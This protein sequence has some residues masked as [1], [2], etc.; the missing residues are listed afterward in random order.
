MF[1][2]LYILSILFLLCNNIQG[3]EIEIIGREWT[4]GNSVK[5]NYKYSDVV[6]LGSFKFNFGEKSEYGDYQEDIEITFSAIKAYKGD[7]S[8]GQEINVLVPKSAIGINGTGLSL[9]QLFVKNNKER[10]KLS[11]EI[12]HLSNQY[13]SGQLNKNKYEIKKEELSQA[14]DNISTPRIIPSWNNPLKDVA[15]FKDK[16]CLAYLKYDADKKKYTFSNAIPPL[17]F[18]IDKIDLHIEN[19][20]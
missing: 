3:S 16:K 4:I 13:E 10:Q 11:N 2:R 17:V 1:I 15:I 20:D 8:P 19:F 7:I 18:D 14:R 6:V 9:L 12:D 5:L